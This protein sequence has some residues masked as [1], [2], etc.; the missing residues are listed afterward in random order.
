[1]RHPD[2]PL[3]VDI[4]DHL[5]EKEVLAQ[6]GARSVVTGFGARPGPGGPLA[7]KMFEPAQQLADMDARGIDIALLSSAAVIETTSWADAQTE[8]MLCR[9]LNDT[10]AKWVAAHPQRFAG[11]FTLPL[12]DMGLAL[13][14]MERAV[15]TLGLKVA[16]LPTNVKGVYLG[17]PAFRP[18]WQRVEQLGV[19]AFIH[20]EGSKDPWF[21]KYALWNT[22]GQSI[23]EAKV[24]A[25]LIYEGIAETFPGLKLIMAHGGGY[26]PHY[27]GRLDR[28]GGSWPDIMRNI[29]GVPSDYLKWFY[30]DACVYDPVVLDHL[31]ELVGPE[32]LLMGS[33]YP[34]G[35]RDPIGLL[36]KSKAVGKQNLAA[37]AGGNA[38]KLLK[39]RT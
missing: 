26:F 10:I 4:H 8:L 5:L 39:L 24:M 30:Y 25:S 15:S 37:I 27:M 21:Q 38:A 13:A 22:V 14:E 6:C 23:E 36:R 11:S 9:R 32:R 28:A 33:D 17:E 19:V 1:M 12:Q 18:F 35:E 34:V 29:K 3:A 16:N 31:I 20:P 7:E 2:I